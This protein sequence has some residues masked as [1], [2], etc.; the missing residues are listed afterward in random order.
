MLTRVVAIRH[1][2]P[3]SEGYADEILRPLSE[4]GKLIQNTMTEH[5]ISLGIK[6]DII[7][8][9]PI[10]RALETA[11]LIAEKF[12]H[13]VPL[14]VINE[15]GYNFNKDFLLNLIPHPSLNQTLYL[16]G[17]SPTLANFIDQLTEEESLIEGLNTSSAAI[18]DFRDEIK[19]K[20]GNFIA[21]YHYPL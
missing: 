19:Y 6:P 18:V 20:K 9:S 10:L 3:K 21:V 12:E 5:L 14:K 17:H 8:T 7:Y 15:L 13:K 4:E 1:A 11:L 16:I 2:K